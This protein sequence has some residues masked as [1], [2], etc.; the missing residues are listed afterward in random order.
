MDKFIE[1]IEAYLK[2]GTPAERRIARYFLDHFYELDLESPASIA[3]RLHLSPMTVGR[4][5]RKLGYDSLEQIAP[6]AQG[7][8]KRSARL[9][10]KEAGA[11][12]AI[13]QTDALALMIND[14]IKAFQ[15]VYLLT[16]Q[17]RWKDISTRIR[18]AQ[19]MYI[20][21]HPKF[22][23]IGTTFREQLLQ[24]SKVIQLLDGVASSYQE[25]F[26]TAAVEDIVLLIIDLDG[27]G[28]LRQLAKSA[29]EHGYEPIVITGRPNVWRGEQQ[30]LLLGLP[31]SSTGSGSVLTLMG[32][33]ECLSAAVKDVPDE[34]SS[35]SVS[36]E[37]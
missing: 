36:E 26:L 31:P 28:D 18:D 7:T 27:T 37:A 19:R 4:F 3:G 29:R 10:T 5:L 25:L 32:L 13:S 1:K 6:R 14:H 33:L 16:Q 34:H 17:R 2:A 35:A 30:G 23:G 21:I 24:G 12:P 9:A 8:R 15:Q 20:V 22:T 11:E